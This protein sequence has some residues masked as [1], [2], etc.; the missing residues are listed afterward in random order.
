MYWFFDNND[1]IKY[2]IIAIKK[3]VYGS[4]SDW[5]HGGG[6]AVTFGFYED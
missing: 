5:V 6:D 1:L 3:G 2:T 4:D